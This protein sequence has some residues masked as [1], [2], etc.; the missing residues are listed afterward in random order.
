MRLKV[1]KMNI[2]YILSYYVFNI[3]IQKGSLVKLLNFVFS[4]LLFF[5]CFIIL[6]CIL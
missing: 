3:L 1:T 5:Y 2:K 4:S 6:L